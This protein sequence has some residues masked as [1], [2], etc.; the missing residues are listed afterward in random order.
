MKMRVFLRVADEQ[1]AGNILRFLQFKSDKLTAK[2]LYQ[3]SQLYLST[4]NDNN[5]PLR[6]GKIVMV[7]DKGL[8]MELRDSKISYLSF[9]PWE[10][11]HEF[12]ISLAEPIYLEKKKKAR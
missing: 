5:S 6:Q 10:A 1:V 11:V 7:N 4:I 2:D 8:T 12:K 9:V 3:D